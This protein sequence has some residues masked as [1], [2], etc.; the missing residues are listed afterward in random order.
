MT[1]KTPPFPPIPFSSN[2][3]NKKMMLN[4]WWLEAKHDKILTD[5]LGV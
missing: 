5:K 1:A 2:N 3:E 4:A